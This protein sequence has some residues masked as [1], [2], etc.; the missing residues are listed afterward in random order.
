M[1]FF[2]AIINSYIIFVSHITVF[3][4]LCSQHCPLELF[5]GA[6]A[7]AADHRVELTLERPVLADAAH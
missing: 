2:Q 7:V 5:D 6:A 3:F 4:K 1:Y